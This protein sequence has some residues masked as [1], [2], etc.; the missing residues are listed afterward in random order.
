LPVGGDC[1]KKTAQRVF[2][3]NFSGVANTSGQFSVIHDFFTLH[4]TQEI[5]PA[6]SVFY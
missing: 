6:T 3:S 5:A 2:E 4:Y 1:A